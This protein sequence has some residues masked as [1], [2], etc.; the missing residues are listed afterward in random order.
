MAVSRQLYSHADW[1][2]LYI[3]TLDFSLTR[4]TCVSRCRRCYRSLRV[5]LKAENET[6]M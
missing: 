1:P 4:C 2:Y 5:R 6:E 3:S